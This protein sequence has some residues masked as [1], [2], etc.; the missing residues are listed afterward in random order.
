MTNKV[1]SA[2]LASKPEVV[3]PLSDCSKEITKSKS[4]IKNS[5]VLSVFMW[6]RA[7]R[8]GVFG[9][10][11]AFTLVELL[12]VVAIIG[13]LVAI[14][15]PVLGK[16]RE[17][18]RQTSCQNNHR[19]IFFTAQFYTSDWGYEPTFVD[20]SGPQEMSWEY[21]L[22][23]YVN[24]TRNSL[25]RTQSIFTCPSHRC[26]NNSP[27]AMVPPYSNVPG[28]FGSSYGL[29][30]HFS[31]SYFSG[32]VTPAMVRYPTK[33]IYFGEHDNFYINNSHSFKYYAWGQTTGLDPGPYI[34]ATWHNGKHLF[35]H[36]DGHIGS[37]AWGALLGTCDGSGNPDWCLDGIPSHR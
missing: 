10:R 13:V 29:N 25:F 20:S 27:W 21:T 37:S 4:V 7:S 8:Q 26:R 34:S 11:A 5:N 19:Q 24:L 28:Y 31:I 3:V 2:D 36:Y 23:P 14:L 1:T 6:P 33:L 35:I 9:S 30:F 18:A 32:L 22:P 12:V 16:T 17:V 15:L